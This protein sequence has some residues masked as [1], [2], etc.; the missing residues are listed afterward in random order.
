MRRLKFLTIFIILLIT[1]ISPVYA[2]D[3]PTPTNDFYVNDYAGV[4]SDSTKQ[5]I[6]Q[7]SVAIQQAT[8]AQIVVVTVDSLNDN[9]LEDFSLSILRSWGIGDEKADN[10]LVMLVAVDDRKSRIE[11]GYGLEGALPDGKTG[12]IQDEYMLPY[13]KVDNY[14]EGIKN[15]YLAVLQEVA[16]EYSLDINNLEQPNL[17]VNTV[18]PTESLSPL[19]KIIIG[20]L[21]VV[22]LIIDWT[23][24]GGRITRAVFYIFLIF[25]GRGGRGGGSSGGGFSGG[26][27]SGGGGGSSRGW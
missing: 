27:G 3:V 12:R 22:L 21:V 24:L 19:A 8:G 26:G 16:T 4:L 15:G 10:G 11:V 13:F 2:I 14:D 20:I 23:L 6:M 9:V 18:E 17:Q 1:M 7:N 25:G 5:L